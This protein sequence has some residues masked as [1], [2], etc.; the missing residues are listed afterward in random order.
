MLSAKRETEPM[1]SATLNSTPKQ[2]RL[3]APRGGRSD[4]S[5]HL[6]FHNHAVATP[7]ETYQYR[8]YEI[9]PMSQWS[10]WCTGV[11]ADL[12]LLMQST[13]ATLADKKE[14]PVAEAKH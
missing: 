8:G 6:I 1:V 14:E 12:A 7:T 9:V 2:A 10:S 4:A 3:N 13:L 11:R 5:L